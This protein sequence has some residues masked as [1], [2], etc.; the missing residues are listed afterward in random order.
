MGKW[1]DMNMLVMAGGCER[2]AIEFRELFD[3]AGWELER[4][5]ATPS[6]LSIIVA[7][8]RA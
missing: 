3:R 6:P 1:M 4:I 2:T 8:P 5:I 7:K